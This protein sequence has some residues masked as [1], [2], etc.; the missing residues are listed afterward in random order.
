MPELLRLLLQR[1]WQRLAALYAPEASVYD[2]VAAVVDCYELLTQIP[3]HAMS[4]ASLDTLT[5]LA[6]MDAQLPEEAESFA[7]AEMFRQAGA[8][9]DT[10]PMLP[11]SA[12][13]ATGV[14]PV[15]YRGEVKPELIQKKM[16]LQELAEELQSLAQGLSPLPPR[17]CKSF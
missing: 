15:P 1:L 5:S 6:D 3:V 12:E 13:P 10:M 14:E 11:D 2:T 8:G 9:A 7:L 16:R 4:T 17:C